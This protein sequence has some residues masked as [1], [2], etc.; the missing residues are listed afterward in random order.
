MQTPSPW[1]R[2]IQS[3]LI[4]GAV[5]IL[6]SLVG[7]VAAFRERYIVN[8]VFTMGQVLF[9]API[10]LFAYSVVLRADARP[11]IRVLLLGALSGLFSSLLLAALV[12]IGQVVDLR[13]MLVN[14]ST[15]LYGIL[16]FGQ[17]YLAG[18][19]ILLGVGLAL[20]GLAAGVRLLPQRLRAAFVQA[21]AW[22]V[23]VGLLRDLI[24]TVS[25]SW[26]S[27]AGVV[28]Y[29]F[30]FSGL[31]PFG[32]VLVFVAVG[33]VNFWRSGRPKPSKASIAASQRPAIRWLKLGGVAAILLLLPPVLG[34]YF[35]EILDNVGMYI[36]MGLGLNIVVGFAGLL[37]LGYVAF[38]AIGAYT[39]GVLTS[40]ELGFFNLTYW[41]ALPFALVA[42]VLSGLILGLPVLKMRGDY[43][44]IV[45]LGF[46]EIVRLLALSDW[47]RPWLGGTQGIQR[48]AQPQIGS[49]LLNSQQEL[50]YLFL[51]GIGIVAFIATRLKDSRIGRAW[52]ALREDEDVAVAMGINHVFTK[53]MAF[54]TGALFSGLA[55]TIFAAKLTSVYPHS[56]N[57]LVS[58][59]V[60][61][62]II[63]GGMGS[64]PG[65]F[66]GALV[67]I[68]SPELLR[69]FAEFRYLAYGAL[70]VVMMLTRP[71]GLWPEARRR[72][73]LHEEEELAAAA[74][75]AALKSTK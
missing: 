16:T 24:V 55:G 60:L 32:A 52:M 15:E 9:L 11:A 27:L 17:E 50:Y 61:C 45:T 74:E 58:I 21:T 2:A 13:V 34:I 54:A 64:I 20:G 46:G 18:L 72:L 68:G 71:E 56:M 70:L 3:G 8:G 4:G 6:L 19:L 67:L 10:L 49:F 35:S 31:K 1:K 57:F 38:F 23:L 75:T 41:Q 44:A 33:A 25:L 30:A 62:L 48:I 7:I 63:I 12:L 69:E 59:N 22:M 5:S 43:L 65:V 73:E 26:G 29:F 14:A 39:M 51:L 37:D 42:C 53:L 28:K 66:V 47:L 40:P 36:L